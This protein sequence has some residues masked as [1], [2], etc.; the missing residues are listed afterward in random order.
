MTAHAQVLNGDDPQP[1]TTYLLLGHEAAERAFLDAYNQGRLPHAWLVTGPRGVGKATFAFR[2]ARFLLCRGDGRDGG[3]GLFGEEEGAPQNLD[4]AEGS[5]VSAQVA[6]GSHPNLTVLRRALDEKSGKLRTAITVDYVRGLHGLFALTAGAGGWRVAIIDPADEMN[7][8]AA[9]ALLKLLEEPPPKS[10]LILVS[11]APGGLLPTIRSRCRQLVLHPVEDRQVADVL[12]RHRPDLDEA[13]RAA[14]AGFAGGSPGRALTLASRDGLDLY[15][16]MIGLLAALPRT[17]VR[18]VHALGERF[19]R[20]G[21]D[22]AYRTFTDLLTDW[23][24]RMVRTAAL[25]QTPDEAVPG[26]AAVMAGLC[27]GRSLDQWIG[28]WEN[29]RHLVVKADTINLD[30]KQVLISLFS[31]LEQAAKP[32]A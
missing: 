18:A 29:V 15:R 25:G 3:L 30:R 2:A 24:Q 26:E 28:V 12:G 21:G 4:V 7:R 13:D 17:D 11:H 10:L 20:K 16:E 8:N 22:E 31:T 9:N 14:I 1:E 27:A 6:A 23:L 32:A 5:R 19:R